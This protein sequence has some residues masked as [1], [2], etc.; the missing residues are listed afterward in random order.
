MTVGDIGMGLGVQAMEKEA[1]K[2]AL[3]RD[4]NKARLEKFMNARE[5]TIGIDMDGL[6]KQIEGKKRLK[7]LEKNLDNF[8]MSQQI[9]IANILE[10]REMDQRRLRAKENEGLLKEWALHA[11]ARKN[12]NVRDLTPIELD[13]CGPASLQC[14]SGE[15][16]DKEERVRLQQIQMKKWINENIEEKKRQREAEKAEDDRYDQFMKYMTEVRGQTEDSEGGLRKQAEK[17]SL[18]INQRLAQQHK[19]KIAAEK[20]AIAA[21]NKL[22]V[23]TMMNDPLL[24]EDPTYVYNG[25]I[26]RDHFRGFSKG[27]LLQ[28][29]KENEALIKLKNNNELD[30]KENE[31]KETL[32]NYLLSKRLEE[33]ELAQAR[34]RKQAQKDILEY[35]KQTA[36]TQ[37]QKKQD[38]SFGD[39]STG[40]FSKFG[41]SFR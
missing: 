36:E 39:M 29:A 5:R 40:Y 25:S 35:N 2:I 4:R 22:E 21:Q 30:K 32:Q 10:A 16:F 23:D 24:C 41:T 19:E 14:F 28:I 27:Q 8:A 26:R 9:K 3:T 33:I 34:D 12:R 13:N 31:R 38:I 20:A 15:D 37:V 1:K 17:V 11:E 18:E 6:S 7:E